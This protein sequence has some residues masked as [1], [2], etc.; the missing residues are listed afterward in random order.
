MYSNIPITGTKKILDY[1]MHNLIDPQMKY[2]LLNWYNIIM[3]QNYFL[4]NNNLIIQNDGL[5]MGAP[6]SSILPE[7]FLQHQEHTHL[8]FLK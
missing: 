1:I 7:I 6:S 2:E 3:K 8:P 4:N 5:A